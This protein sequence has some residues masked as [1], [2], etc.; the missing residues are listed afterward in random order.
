M[1]ADHQAGPAII[2]G[3]GS[4]APRYDGFILDLWGVL[5]D[6]YRPYPGAVEALEALQR[7]GK[8]VVILSN[9]PRRAEAVIERIT[10]IGIPSGTY[11]RV[12]SSGEEAWQHLKQRDDPFYR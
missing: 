10:E 7:E 2:A 11:D 8:H 1:L 3:L 5:H 6:G 12:L 4:L 9:A